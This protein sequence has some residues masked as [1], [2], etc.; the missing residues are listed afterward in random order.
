[1]LRKNLSS[2]RLAR[3]GVF[4]LLTVTTA[5]I[6]TT[7]AAEARRHRR[8][9]AHHRV[10]R[11]VS[12]SSSP[13]FASIIVDGNSGSVLQATSPD[14][15]RHPA[16]LTKI[17]TLY[18]LFE[19]LE[20]GKMKLDTEM[21]VSQHAADQDP[22][23][24]NLRAGQTIRVEDAIKGLVTRSANDAAVVIAEAI[25]GDED[26]FAQMMTRKA[27][28]LGMSK[29]V[30][31][32]ANGLPND[33]QVTTA[34]DQATLGR[35]I[36]ERFPR[37][38]RYFAT[39]TFNW[40]GQ[41]IRNHNHLLG[42]VEGVDGIK[43]GYTRASGFNLVTSM[44]RG[45]RHLIGVVLGG[46]SGGSRDAIMRNLLAENLEKGATSHT[47]AAVT[48][49]SG[50]DAA[51]EVA[52]ASDTPARTAPQVQAAAAPAPEAAPSRLA[53]RLSTLAAATAAMPPAQPKPEAR[54]TESKIE[55]APLTNG[56]ISSQPLS[57]IP[58][59]SEPMKPVRVKT[60]QVK[61]GTV[62]VASAAPSQVAPQITNT[63]ASRSD[64]AETS[65]A[66]VA[67]AD[68][69]NKP[70]IQS[71][72]EAPKAEVAR[73]ELPR[74]PAGFGTGNGVLGVLPAAT[75]AA[76]A[77][78][79]P[80]LASA[81]PAPQPIQMSATTKPVVTHSG[82]IVQVGALES[83]NEAQQRIDAARSSARGLLS[84]ADPFTEPVVA[85]DNRKLYRA[86]FA[87]LE[88]DQAEAV[89]RALKRADISC[90]TVRN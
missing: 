83:E 85:K 58:G 20:S 9:Y 35:A 63:V 55:P 7:D 17:M 50:A 4:G 1:M 57:I 43:T 53:S 34:R 36:Q 72:P 30:Y 79:A 90:I 10:Q 71:Q 15:I 14:G 88:R 48:E 41:S 73:T 5:V 28:S 76:P 39:S 82:W 67:R 65:G 66:V 3:V 31:R 22:T 49:R 33:E 75:A 64:V 21:P 25:A 87:G 40:R 12:E 2:S 60:V 77:P 42:S 81:D 6:F 27:R 13:K 16:S 32:N 18:L 74:Q 68:L 37:Y 51:A 11:D 29:T 84:K 24:L 45:N 8:H 46:R 86:R 26:D 62:K 44:R 59:S 70:E 54:P 80:K 89:C 78:V 19:R 61:A 38:Y 69:I 56:V 23:K 52:D 47:V